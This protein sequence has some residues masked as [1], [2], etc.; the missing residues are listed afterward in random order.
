MK[1]GRALAVFLI[2]ATVGEPATSSARKRAKKKQG[3]TPLATSLKGEAK[4][5]YEQA[6]MLFKD[7]DYP[8]A[9]RRYEKSYEVQPD[10]RLLWNIAVCE[11]QL[12]HYA[13][14]P[15]L[16]VTF[17]EKAAPLITDEERRTAQEFLQAVRALV[18]EITFACSDPNIDVLI[19]EAHVEAAC[20]AP[21]TLEGGEHRLNASKSGFKPLT[22]TFNVPSGGAKS[23]SVTL[24]AEPQEA[25][26]SIQAKADDL[27]ALDGRGVGNQTWSGV[28]SAGRHVVDVTA[29]GKKAYHAQIDI[30][31][32]DDQTVTVTLEEE[33]SS[34][35]VWL[36]VAGGALVLAGAA[37][38]GYFA[39]RPGNPQPIPGTLG[40]HAL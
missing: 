12:R 3:P 6:G 26:L 24:E 38:G 32:R 30:R 22:L 31:A 25:R 27:I 2:I 15:P 5:E 29:P 20:T 8:G 28:L 36:L 19:D 11:K 23:V 37:V 17:L 1:I 13:K 40:S 4:T 21:L 10:P 33:P 9:L 34:F 14:V 18:G 35:P 39:L 16:V 7:G